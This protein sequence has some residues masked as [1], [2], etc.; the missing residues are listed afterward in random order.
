MF[1]THFEHDELTLEIDEHASG[2]F[3]LLVPYLF[4]EDKWINQIFDWKHI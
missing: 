2:F 1:N 3:F 4:W